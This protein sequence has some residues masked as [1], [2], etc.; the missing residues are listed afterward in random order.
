MPF[1]APGGVIIR[2]P[3]NKFLTLS[4]VV[5]LLSS[6][7]KEHKISS[8]KPRCPAGMVLVQGGEEPFCIHAYEVQFQGDLGNKDQGRDYPDGSTNGSLS[9]A[10]GLV[11]SLTSW[12]QAY[13]ACDQAGMALCTSRQWRWACSGGPGKGGRAYPTPD[14]EYRWFQCALRDPAYS[15]NP[16]LTPSGA[17]PL[18]TTPDGVFDM[19]GNVWEWTDPDNP[20]AGGRVPRTDK[21][22]AAHY[23]VGAPRCDRD[24]AIGSHPPDF[25]GTVGF[26]CCVP[27]K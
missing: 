22:G 26:R 21:L 6:G 24:N 23:S 3:C 16:P 12:Y 2:I 17:F 1:Q 10:P 25:K 27:P 20:K 14:G 19:V 15:F 18:C 11:P 5:C 8:T 9:S 13:A 4:L 7:C